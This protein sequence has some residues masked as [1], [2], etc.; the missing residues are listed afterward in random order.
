MIRSANVRLNAGQRRKL[1][2]IAR[3]Y[4]LYLLLLPAVAFIVV[5]KYVPM[6]G[7]QLAFKDFSAK[8]GIFGSP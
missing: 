2:Q 4:D 8:L 7:V 6:Y 3:N 5:F 1:T